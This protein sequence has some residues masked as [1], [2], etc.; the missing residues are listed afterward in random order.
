MPH[1]L[2]IRTHRPS[3]RLIQIVVRPT[4][5][6]AVE[7]HVLVRWGV[8][9]CHLRRLLCA[10]LI[11]HLPQLM[12]GSRATCHRAC[13][14]LSWSRTRIFCRDLQSIQTRRVYR[15]SPRRCECRPARANGGSR[16][17]PFPLQALTPLHRG[18]EPRT[19]R[20]GR[21]PSIYGGAVAPPSESSPV[22]FTNR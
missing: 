19:L 3:A 17:T 14:L 6:T 9:P 20:A 10:V 5:C 15:W 8:R 1:P 4:S 11:L 7:A 18:R 16:L 21:P 12:R 22:E 13:M 2:T